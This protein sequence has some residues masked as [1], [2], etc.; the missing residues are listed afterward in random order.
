MNSAEYTP[1]RNAERIRSQATR[2]IRGPVFAEV[3][4][5]LMAAVKAGY[6]GRLKKDGL[7]PE[8]FF[9]PDHYHGA[10]ERQNSEA[11][12]S[13]GLIAK[14]MVSGAERAEHDF[15]TGMLNLRAK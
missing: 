15:S 11:A 1:G 2:V 7:R 4:R 6:L 5:E 3:R 10:I 14:V 9:H 12:Y 13:V 8:I